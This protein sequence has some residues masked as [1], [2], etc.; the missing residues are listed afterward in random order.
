MLV[1][2]TRNGILSLS[3]VALLILSTGASAKS[4]SGLIAF[5]R[6]PYGG[7]SVVPAE[8]GKPSK[9]T[10]RHGQP[11]YMGKGV[12]PTWSPDGEWL[13]IVDSRRVPQGHVCLGDDDYRCPAE[14]YVMRPDGSGERRIT[15]TYEELWQPPIWSPDSRK[16]AFSAKGVIRVVDADGSDS[17]RLPTGASYAAVGSWSPDGKTIAYTQT[18]ARS[19]IF[20]IGLD[21][22]KRR[23]TRDGHSEA[24]VWSPDGRWI[25]YLRDTP[26]GGLSLQLC[27]MKP[28]GSAQRVLVR[29]GSSEGV[30]WS[31]DASTLAYE[32]SIKIDTKVIATVE[33]RSGR[34]RLLV[35]QSEDFWTSP[36]WS[37]DGTRLVATV[38]GERLRDEVWI[39]S[40]TGPPNKRL[41][42][43][44]DSA[45][46]QPAR[47]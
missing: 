32:N 31:P 2:M 46:W 38:S 25:A 16:L 11:W 21:G 33:I 18:R 28:D 1:S 13:A 41:V 7:I 17:R 30:A 22:R 27:L 42:N 47:R 29:R 35:P 15:A 3:A 5:Q 44:G 43:G 19:D 12:A 26:A 45:S 24:P 20:L 36:S 4:H 6:E 14:I 23:L 39:L 8:G 37:P 10:T 40:Y 34:Q 9:L